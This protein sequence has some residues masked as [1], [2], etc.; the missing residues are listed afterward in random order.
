MLT[1]PIW[2]ALGP[3]SLIMSNSNVILRLQQMRQILDEV[4]DFA[5]WMDAVQEVVQSQVK[6]IPVP[7]GVDHEEG[8]VA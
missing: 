2:R 4:Y 1:M 3:D 8:D 7:E 5:E 6:A